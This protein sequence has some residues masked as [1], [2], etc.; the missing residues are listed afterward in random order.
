MGLDL[1]ALLEL[2][3]VNMEKGVTGSKFPQKQ[4]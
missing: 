4:M 1:C 2:H 3:S